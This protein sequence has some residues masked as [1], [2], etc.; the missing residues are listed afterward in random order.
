MLSLQSLLTLTRAASKMCRS[1]QKKVKL[2]S[3]FVANVC[4]L[5][6]RACNQGS[7][8]VCGHA[9]V[10][11]HASAELVLAQIFQC[12]DDRF[13]IFTV[14]SWLQPRPIYT[15]MF[16]YR[17]NRGPACVYVCTL[18]IFLHC[19]ASKKSWNFFFVFKRFL[20]VCWHVQLLKSTTCT[21]H[22]RARLNNVC[23]VRFYGLCGADRLHSQ[24]DLRLAGM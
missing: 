23:A 17:H 14:Q 9:L 11:A 24:L 6:T 18:S 20:R 8:G 16:G 3:E 19:K 5:F 21:V 2:N 22:A 4:A 13:V 15:L 1:K 7:S 10:L 12:L